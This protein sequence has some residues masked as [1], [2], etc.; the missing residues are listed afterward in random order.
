MTSIR[1]AIDVHGHCVP[2]ALLEEMLGLECNDV[3]VHHNDGAYVVRFDRSA[4][5][6]AISGVMLDGET[7]RQ[8]LDDQ[9]IELQFVAPWLDVYAAQLPAR[10]GARWV[11]HLNDHMAALAANSGG[12]LRAHAALH[13]GDAAT[14][15]S[16]LTRAVQ[17]LA[18]TTTMMPASVPGG[19]LSDP[20]FDDLWATAEELKV[21]VMLHATSGS[22]AL[23]L[24]DE[25]PRLAGLFGRN[26]EVALAAADLIVAGVLDRH[27]ELRL[28]LVH[29]G[30]FLPY[31]TGRFDND[32]RRNAWPGRLP[33][34]AMRDLYYDTVLLAPAAI[35]CLASVAGSD[36]IMLGSDFGSTPT[37]RDALR[38]TEPV[39]RTALDAAAQAGILRDNAIRL[40]DL[41]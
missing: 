9:E 3:A 5:L 29:G 19:R 41:P 31:L 2:R 20:A 36:R 27:P 22:A 14:A 18:M 11:R 35:D 15:A 32:A 23:A 37:E 8:W 40:L 12:H 26:I 25:Y 21:M 17:Q 39:T 7:R 1:G 34:K 10:D 30:G 13:P 24:V 6:R 33:S 16:E 4:P 38:V 28:L